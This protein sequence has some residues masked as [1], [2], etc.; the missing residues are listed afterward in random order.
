MNKSLAIATTLFAVNVAPA[1]EGPSIHTITMRSYSKDKWVGFAGYGY[2][3]ADQNPPMTW[4]TYPG[5]YMD[6]NVYDFNGGK[7]MHGDQVAFLTA[8]QFQKQFYWTAD[9]AGKGG[10]KVRTDVLGAWERFRIWKVNGSGEIKW[11]SVVKIETCAPGWFVS[12]RLDQNIEHHSGWMSP[13]ATTNWAQG[14][15]NFLIGP[16]R[17]KA[18]DW[19]N[20]KVGT[21]WTPYSSDSFV[22]YAY[23]NSPYMEPNESALLDRAVRQGVLDPTGPHYAGALVVYEYGNRRL[24]GVFQPKAVILP[25][26]NGAADTIRKYDSPW[27]GPYCPEIPGARLLGSVE[28]HSFPRFYNW[29]WPN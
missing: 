10:I 19:T 20:A 16:D 8:S 5:G 17:P 27:G 28:P 24:W 9:N 13:I 12:A 25:M 22:A 15:E 3:T 2:L 11:K 18:K 23:E 4:N 29:D 26:P 21:S 6:I 14:W 1:Y 7:L